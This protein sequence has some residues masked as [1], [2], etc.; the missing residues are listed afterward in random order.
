M[1][2][3]LWPSLYF[4]SQFCSFLYMKLNTCIK[5]PLLLGCIIANVLF[6]SISWA[7]IQRWA[8]LIGLNRRHLWVV[9][10]GYNTSMAEANQTVTVATLSLTCHPCDR[11]AS[12]NP[13]MSQGRP[14]VRPHVSYPRSPHWCRSGRN[15]MHHLC[16]IITGQISYGKFNDHQ[17]A[18]QESLTR[19]HDSS[20]GCRFYYHYLLLEAITPPHLRQ[21][22]FHSPAFFDLLLL[23]LL[24]IILYIKFSHTKMNSVSP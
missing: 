18:N 23:L 12:L 16:F 14:Q 10:P 9:C 15:T 24:L 5:L 3:A 1:Y 13:V 19:P 22:F 8:I 11:P 7:N 20:G 17:S 21:N 2:S 6:C 4:R